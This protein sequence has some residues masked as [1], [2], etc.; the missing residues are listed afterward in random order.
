MTK[1]LLMVDINT[2]ERYGAPFA[3]HQPQKMTLQ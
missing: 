3:F 2:L 1:M